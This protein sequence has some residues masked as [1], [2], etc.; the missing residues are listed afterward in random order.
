MNFKRIGKE[1]V[2][3]CSYQGEIHGSSESISAA[4]GR[5]EL[6]DNDNVQKWHLKFFISE[7]IQI[8]STVTQKNNNGS[9]QDISSL[10]IDGIDQSSL[11]AVKDFL[12]INE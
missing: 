2:H 9:N 7:N 10:S 1:S 8:V 6:S 12:S 4:F 11:Y 5:P 3:H